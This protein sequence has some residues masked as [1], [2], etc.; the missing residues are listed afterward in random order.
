[1]R[2]AQG[3]LADRFRLA[4]HREHREIAG[5]ELSIGRGGPKLQEATKAA[6]SSG[7]D[8]GPGRTFKMENGFP[9]FPAGRGGLL[10]LNGHFRWTALNITMG[11]V[12][13]MLALQLGAPVIDATSLQG[14]YNID[15]YWLQESVEGRGTGPAQQDTP[16]V[17][18]PTVPAGPLLRQALQDQLGLKLGAK[19]TAVEVIVVD[20]TER[21]PVGN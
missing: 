8:I 12:L 14:K 20:H 18:D 1:M 3:M 9:V 2:M 15:L 6:V 19:K 13:K 11:D 16:G 4:V 21:V 17:P 7:E 10:G 5:Y